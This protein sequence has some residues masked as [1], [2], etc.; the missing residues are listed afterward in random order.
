MAEAPQRF[1]LQVCRP[2]QGGH[3]QHRPRA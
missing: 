1:A 3:L 2:G